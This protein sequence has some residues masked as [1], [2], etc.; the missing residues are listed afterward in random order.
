MKETLSKERASF[1]VS[2]RRRRRR[3]GLRAPRWIPRRREDG[4]GAGGGVRQGRGRCRGRQDRSQL[5]RTGAHVV[6]QNTSIAAVSDTV[7]TLAAVAVAA[8]AVGTAA[9]AIA[10]VAVGTAAVAV[11]MTVVVVAAAVA[12]ALTVVAAATAGLVLQYVPLPYFVCRILICC[13]LC[14]A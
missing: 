8:V 3:H 5:P 12:A 14:A 1:Q 10:V 13:R 4:D 11:A 2:D 9:V 7:D 6:Q